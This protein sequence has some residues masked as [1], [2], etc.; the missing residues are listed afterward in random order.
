MRGVS[1]A[2][3]T[4]ITLLIIPVVSI[5]AYGLEDGL[6]SSDS[7]LPLSEPSD[8]FSEFTY[9]NG[10][11]EI[12]TFL[13]AK[14]VYSTVTG[15]DGTLSYK[16]YFLFD[17]HGIPSNVKVDNAKGFL[18]A[19]ITLNSTS[20]EIGYDSLHISVG[21]KLYAD[22]SKYNNYSAQ[23][24]DGTDTG[25]IP[26]ETYQIS[27]QDDAGTDIPLSIFSNISV[28]LTLT[29]GGGAHFVKFIAEN[30][31]I[32]TRFYMDHERFGDLPSVG[33][34][35]NVQWI[36]SHNNSVHSDDHYEYDGDMVMHAGNLVDTRVLV[37]LAVLFI[38]TSLCVF[39]ILSR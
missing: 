16:M 24:T 21:D 6:E 31:V 12:V 1:V 26:G 32:E 2:I 9:I 15:P 3:T 28:T 4:A 19:T 27:V 5:S 36:D 7:E 10:T 23:I 17:C 14:N 22:V 35:H 37:I 8:A 30:E 29:P 38:V 25:L 33:R 39:L 20:T 13:E 18:F 11:R 34:N